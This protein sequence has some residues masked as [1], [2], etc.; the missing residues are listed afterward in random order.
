MLLFIRMN[1]VNFDKLMLEQS[2]N[3]GER[4]R[5]LLHCCCAPCST[6]CFEK[7]AGKF[8]ITAFFYNPNIEPG[9]YE[10]RKA[11]LIRYISYTGVAAI[12]DCD[13]EP[14]VF[15]SAVKG[16]ENLPEGGERCFACYKLRLEKTA[17]VA[18][19]NNFDFFATTL[20]LSPLKNA[21]KINEIGK[22]LEKKAKWLYSDFKKRNGYLRSL[23]LS[24][25]FGLYRQNYCGCVFSKRGDIKT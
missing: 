13:Y 24:Q 25:Q 8:E 3:C 22:S 14:E 19:E 1:A 18:D 6:A 15:Y 2:E 23:E 4:N 12:M 10:K 7:L 20:T 17:R 16:L 11:E 9:E 21:A 5:L